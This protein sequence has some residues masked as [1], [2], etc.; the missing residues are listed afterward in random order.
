MYVRY[1]LQTSN[2][3]SNLCFIPVTITRDLIKTSMRKAHKRSLANLRRGVQMD[4][5]QVHAALADPLQTQRLQNQELDIDQIGMAQ[6][7]CLECAQY[8]DNDLALNE[9]KKGSKHKRRVKA[10][11]EIPYS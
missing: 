8:F 7:Y 4:I 6:H 11:K 2:Y 5:D 1:T 10:L 9:H 3:S